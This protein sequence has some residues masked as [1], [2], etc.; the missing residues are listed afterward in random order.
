MGHRVEAPE[1]PGVGFE[2]FD[3]SASVHA[4]QQSTFGD[5]F[6]DVFM[7]ERRRRPAAPDAAPICMRR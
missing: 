4:N 3:F 6:A 5:L 7:R 2:G 1:M